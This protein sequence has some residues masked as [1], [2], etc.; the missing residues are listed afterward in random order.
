MRN[1]IG[2]LQVGHTPGDGFFVNISWVVILV[3]EFVITLNRGTGMLL[4]VLD[5][6]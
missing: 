3:I 4:W 2:L 6:P 1:V 5:A